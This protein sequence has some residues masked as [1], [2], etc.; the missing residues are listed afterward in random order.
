[1]TPAPNTEFPSPV[2]DITDVEQVSDVVQ[3]G[4]DEVVL[5]IVVDDAVSS[6][7]AVVAVINDDTVEMVIVEES[8]KLEEVMIASLEVE[9]TEEVKEVEVVKSNELLVLEELVTS[10]NED[11]VKAVLV[12]LVEEEEL[13]L[14]D[15]NDDNDED[16]LSNKLLNTVDVTSAAEDVV[17]DVIIIGISVLDED[18]DEVDVIRDWDEGMELV[19][20]KVVGEVDAAEAL[21]EE[22]VVVHFDDGVVRTLDE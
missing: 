5:V 15:N 4:A 8:E 7:D 16:E 3:V 6:L 11:G 9:V 14:L 20:D 13:S 10:V 1:M 19:T 2:E 21:D 12:T 22:V 17:E 18:V